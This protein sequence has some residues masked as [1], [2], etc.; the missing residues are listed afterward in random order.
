MEWGF[1]TISAWAVSASPI[2]LMAIMVAYCFVIAFLF[3]TLFWLASL[4][5]HVQHNRIKRNK[6]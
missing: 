2:S 6:K 5:E 4:I 3:Y 1:Q